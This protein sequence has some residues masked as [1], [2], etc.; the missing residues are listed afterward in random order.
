[1]IKTTVTINCEG[2]EARPIAMLV[3]KVDLPTPPLPDATVKIFAIIY[4]HFIPKNYQFN[5][6]IKHNV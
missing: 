4:P 6:I 2:L 1:M 5:F 3:Q